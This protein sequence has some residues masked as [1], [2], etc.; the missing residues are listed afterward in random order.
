VRYVSVRPMQLLNGL[1]IQMNRSLV[2]RT[3][4]IPIEPVGTFRVPT[5]TATVSNG[6]AVAWM[7]AP[8]VGIDVAATDG[9]PIVGQTRESW[10]SVHSNV[11]FRCSARV[12]AVHDATSDVMRDVRHTTSRQELFQ[13]CLA[14]VGEST[15][16]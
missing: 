5:A 6:M 12:V 7:S 8:C 9:P 3:M 4:C 13:R 11:D 1:A 2:L 10:E 16:T 14:E 15:A